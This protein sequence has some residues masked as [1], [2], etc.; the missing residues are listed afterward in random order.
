MRNERLREKSGSQKNLYK[1]GEEGILK[2]SK[3]VENM[4]KKT[5]GGTMEEREGWC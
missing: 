3:H 4:N 5:A 2:W 1:E